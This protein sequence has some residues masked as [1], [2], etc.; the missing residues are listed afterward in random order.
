MQG[1]FIHKGD[2]R[3]FWGNRMS[4]KHELGSEPRKK[5]RVTRT[6]LCTSKINQHQFVSF[7]LRSQSQNFEVA[8]AAKSYWNGYTIINQLFSFFL[9]VTFYLLCVYLC[10]NNCHTW[11]WRRGDNIQNQFSPSTFT[12]ALGPNSCHQA[13]TAGACLPAEPSCQCLIFKINFSETTSCY[14]EQTG[15]EPLVILNLRLPLPLLSRT[16][17]HHNRP[18]LRPP[19]KVSNLVWTTFTSTLVQGPSI[20]CPNYWCLTIFLEDFS[21]GSICSDNLC[22][23][24]WTQL[25]CQTTVPVVIPERVV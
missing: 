21:K 14:V 17:Y 11:M 7:V 18:K 1:L 22:L 3:A 2:G 15:F 9:L 10:L 6:V 12:Q 5:H 24:F 19:F 8:T 13:W 16:L 23:P 4:K 20:S 25:V